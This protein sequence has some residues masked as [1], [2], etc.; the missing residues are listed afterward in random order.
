M[1]QRP[2]PGE[3]CLDHVAHFVPDLQA[4]A[5]ALEALGLVVTPESA[6]RTQH[7]PAGTS[8]R[9]LMLEQGYVEILA[10]TLDTPNAQ[11]VRDRMQRYIGVHLC[12]FG[13][14]DPAGEHARLAA[15]GFEPEPLVNLARNLPDGTPVRFNVVYVPPAKMPEGRIQYCEHLTEAEMWREGWVNGGLR[16]DAAFV[17]AGDPAEVAARWARY[18][19]VLPRREGDLVALPLARGKVLV[20]TREALAVHLGEAPPAPALAGYS[21]KCSQ[22]AEFAARC[23]SAGFRVAGNIVRLPAALGGVW[24]I[25]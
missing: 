6:H 25:G 21:L 1:N 13:T 19:G 17:V 8:N 12:C 23:S 18:S 2:P 9:C 16:L 11:R 5:S 14:P 10:P 24:V 7:G 4:A 20:G 22:P 15:S 3:L